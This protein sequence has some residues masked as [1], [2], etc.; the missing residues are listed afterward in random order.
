MDEDQRLA[1]Q[2]GLVKDHYLK[3]FNEDL[4]AEPKGKVMKNC[5]EPCVA[6]CKKMHGIYK[7]DYEPYQ[8]MG[9]LVG[10]FDQRAAEKLNHHADAMGFDGISI[11]GVLAWIM[12]C[13]DADLLTPA[14]LGVSRMPVFSAFGFGAVADSMA[15]AELG[16][17]L[18]DRIIEGEGMLDLSA[19][20]REL[21]RRLTRQTDKPI[22]DRFVYTANA[23]TGW[24]V[25]NQ[26]WTP[27]VLSPMPIMGKYYN[28]YGNE[29]LPPRALGNINVGRMKKELVMDN[30]GFCRFHRGWAEEMVPEIIGKL[31]GMQTEFVDATFAIAEQICC[32]NDSVYWESERNVDFVHTCLRR[33]RDVDGDKSQ[34]LSKWLDHFEK[35]KHD[36]AFE[37]WFE[38]RKGVQEALRRCR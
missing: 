30:S 26:Y 37:Y 1:I 10:V 14:E 20:A 28:H 12:D 18:I 4:F 5:G 31:F 35:D 2:N 7:K 23:R 19:G 15:N 16:I 34:E 8:A 9:P 33:M 11:G 3:Q 22:L 13:M 36:A 25:P 21:G 17:E 24:M 32:R 29:F 38:V 27:G 6:V